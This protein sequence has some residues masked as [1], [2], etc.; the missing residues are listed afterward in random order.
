MLPVLQQLAGEHRG[1]LAVLKVRAR[2]EGGWVKV[3]GAACS[4]CVRLQR[5]C[6][7]CVC[8]CRHTTGLQVDC[9]KTA[10]NQALAAE[11][12]VSA[13]PTFHLYR[14]ELRVAEMR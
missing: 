4:V 11:A 5:V 7:C 14:D 1:R 12:R 9:E 3:G 8:D 13:F 2:S 10:A 6:M